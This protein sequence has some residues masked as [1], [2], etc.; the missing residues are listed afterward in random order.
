MLCVKTI[1]S[2][3][4]RNDVPKS[5]TV[6][7]F[8]WQ[9]Q[10]LFRLFCAHSQFS[11]KRI[12]K[13]WQALISESLLTESKLTS[14]R[15]PMRWR[16]LDSY[17]MYDKMSSFSLVLFCSLYSKCFR[18]F[19]TL[20]EKTASEWNTKSMVLEGICYVL[21]IYFSFRFITCGLKGFTNLTSKARSNKLL[22]TLVGG[23]VGYLRPLR[24]FIK[25]KSR[26]LMC[27]W[28][29]PKGDNFL[30]WV[31]L[32][33]TFFIVELPFYEIQPLISQLPLNGSP[34]NQKW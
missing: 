7:W 13:K 15:I 14:L 2:G 34:P 22:S 18:F 3:L 23:I 5:W 31:M 6:C 32:K 8:F 10:S 26:V 19:I 11:G 12:A 21:S 1:S 24:M 30:C 4:R 16:R 33:K 17:W 29:Y 20:L 27:I 25:Q 28:T 9:L